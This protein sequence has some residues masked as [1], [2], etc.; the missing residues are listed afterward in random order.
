VGFAEGDLNPS[1]FGRYTY[2][3]NN[4]VNATDPNGE[5]T[6]SLKAEFR[7]GVPGVFSFRV[8][9][10]V[11]ASIPDPFTGGDFDLGV[12]GSVGGT[13]ANVDGVGSI[14]LGAKGSI[15]AGISAG[16]VRDQRGLS[17]ETGAQI[18]VTGNP[19]GPSVG[20]NL[21]FDPSA[22]AEAPFGGLK[23]GE[24]SLGIG[25]DVSSTVNINGAIT[26][27]D[28]ANFVGD[29]VSG[30][31]DGNGQQSATQAAT[32]SNGENC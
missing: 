17:V 21:N 8:S 19:A 14:G 13:P 26:V 11:A 9:V 7:V 1:R 5:I 32:C 23:G 2:T 27:R 10:G 12:V 16:G 29:L 28:V 20:G 3:Y 4:P 30:G 25:T 6:F 15:N 31:Q 18:P 22:P 24:L